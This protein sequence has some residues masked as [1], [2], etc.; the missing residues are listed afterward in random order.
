MVQMALQENKWISHI[1]PMQTA[2]KIHKYVL[3]GALVQQIELEDNRED[4]IVWRWTEDGEYTSKS[5]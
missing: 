5:A 1:T 4:S 3:L 2:V